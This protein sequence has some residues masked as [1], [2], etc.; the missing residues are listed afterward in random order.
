MPNVCINFKT[1][2]QWLQCGKISFGSLDSNVYTSYEVDSLTNAITE[3]VD[4]WATDGWFSP[5]ELKQLKKVYDAIKEEYPNI[6]NQANDLGITGSTSQYTSYTESY[7]ALTATCE[8]YYFKGWNDNSNVIQPIEVE[9]TI[10]GK[11]YGYGVFSTYEKCRQE[12]LAYFSLKVDSRLTDVQAQ[13]TSDT[14]ELVDTLRNEVGEQADKKVD[15]HYQGYDPALGEYDNENKAYKNPWHSDD[16]GD[17]YTYYINRIGDLWFDT[18]TKRS[19]ILTLGEKG[20]NAGIETENTGLTVL[21][22]WADSYVSQSV[23][24]TID[25]K[26][27]VFIGNE[28]S[29][30]YFISFF[31][32]LSLL[33]VQGL[34]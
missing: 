22:Y 20:V 30:P 27:Q 13:I 31:A 32:T 23:Y 3:R 7:S 12:L 10:D 29:T 34:T 14:K 2:H 25:G 28:P 19:Y 16:T 4:T 21:C 18:S 17:T 1:G 6:L 11:T 24:D 5:T 9:K 33:T 8:N 26:S 15:M